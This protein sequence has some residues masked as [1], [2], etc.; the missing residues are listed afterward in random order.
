[1][2]SQNLKCFYVPTTSSIALTLPIPALAIKPHLG[3]CKPIT[4]IDQPP[5]LG[6]VILWKLPPSCR[7]ESA[8]LDAQ[9]LKTL[10]AIWTVLFVTAGGVMS[11]VPD[12]DIYSTEITPP[13]IVI[14]ASGSVVSE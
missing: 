3:S 7:I 4:S 5:G 1:M 14:L 8:N 12:I 10:Q 9:H 13:E 6:V 11:G 2:P